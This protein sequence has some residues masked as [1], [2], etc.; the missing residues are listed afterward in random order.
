MKTNLNKKKIAAVMA[1]SSLA[2]LTGCGSSQNNQAAVPPPAVGAGGYGAGGCIPI[3]STTQIPFTA[4]NM[5]LGSGQYGDA[6]VMAGAIPYKQA[7]GQVILGGA[8]APTAPTGYG[9]GGQFMGKRVDG[10]TI[11]LNVTAGGAA[12]PPTYSGYPS[13]GYGTSG[14]VTAN[15]Y[16]QVSPFIQQVLM[17]SAAN[18]GGYGNTGFPM[19]SQYPNQYPNQYPAGYPGGVAGGQACV[20]NIAIDLQH[21]TGSYANWL[22]L[23]SIYFFVNGTQHG[24]ALDF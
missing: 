23:G 6:H 22:Y 14:N 8:A 19:P 1:L 2:L 13:N 4:T 11:S 3:N 9:Y 20:S 18:S 12:V 21:G 15:G 16:I 17:Q 5:Y 24:L 10:T 7:Y